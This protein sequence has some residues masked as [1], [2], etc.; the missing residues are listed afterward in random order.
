MSR[1]QVSTGTAEAITDAAHSFLM[2]L[3]ADQRDQA[4]FEFAS[5]ERWNWHYVPRSRNGLPR[6]DID[7][8]QTAVAESL[9][10][11]GLSENGLRKAKAIIEHELILGWLETSDG[12]IR[13]DRDPGLYFFTVYGEPGGQGPWGWRVDGHH[14][15]LNYTLVDGDIAS[16]TPSFFGANPAE[17]KSGP[18]KGLRIL[19]EEEE[20]ARALFVSLDE[21]Q[22]R[23]AVIYPE[24]PA[25]IITRASRAVEIEEPQGLPAEAMSARQRELL[26]T[27]VKVYVERKPADVAARALE[28]I[29]AEGVGDIHFA[30]AGSDHRG[31]K[32][33]YRVHGPSFFAEYDNTQDMANHIHSVWRDTEGDFGFDALREHYDRHH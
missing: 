18:S 13:F 9:M 33:Y 32:H 20:A 24:V 27:L 2:A 21:D 28:R 29:E 4:A 31:Q 7:V 15:S 19:R 30:W 26:M 12:T 11:S 23:L 8:G 16:V 25:D 22:K 14:L 17:V 3:T 6:G 1:Q 5:E 10:A